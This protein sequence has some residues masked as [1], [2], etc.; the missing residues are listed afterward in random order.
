MMF[1]P[2]QRRFPICVLRCH[3]VMIF[4]QYAAFRRK[5]ALV[6]ERA[7]RATPLRWWRSPQM[8]RN[9]PAKQGKTALHK[10]NREGCPYKIPPP[11][12]TNHPKYFYIYPLNVPNAVFDQY[13]APRQT[14]LRR[15]SL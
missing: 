4:A 14:L 15:V 2:V 6:V 3:F 8:G 1:A 10:G 5:W 11:P 9:T 12:L 7:L 13:N